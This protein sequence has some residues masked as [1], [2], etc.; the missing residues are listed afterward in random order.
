MNC[1]LLGMTMVDAFL[2]YEGRRGGHTIMEK[3]QF[4]CDLATQLIRND[5]DDMG[6]R[7][8]YGQA[9][10]GTL[11]VPRSGTTTRLKPTKRRRRDKDGILKPYRHQGVCRHRNCPKKSKWAC[12]SC[13]DETVLQAS[14]VL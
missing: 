6:L 7:C 11:S 3:H 10:L 14:T 4:W 2:L 1:T 9:S 13:L 8:R 12:S 5:F